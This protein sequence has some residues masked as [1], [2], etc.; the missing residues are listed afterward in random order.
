MAEAIR[1]S[2]GNVSPVSDRLAEL[3]D[4][5]DLLAEVR[6]VERLA[7]GRSVAITTNGKFP[8]GWSFERWVAVATFVSV[9]FGWLFFAG[10]EWKGVKQDVSSMKTDVAA[11]KTNQ[12]ETQ[13]M[14]NVL[15]IE[16]ERMRVEAERVER[17]D[18]YYRNNGR[19][20]SVFGNGESVR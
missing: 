7:L 12:D 4:D 8:W 9:V 5:R 11:L 1:D 14:L 16:I 6:A 13:R 20:P 3:V 2:H 19:R 15:R 10:G 17:A 18:E